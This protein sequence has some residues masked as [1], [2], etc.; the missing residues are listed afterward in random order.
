[1]DAYGCVGLNLCGTMAKEVSV[2]AAWRRRVGRGAEARGHVT[3]FGGE[4]RLLTQAPLLLQQTAQHRT[5]Q[6][7]P[8]ICYLQTRQLH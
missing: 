6:S 5:S 1:M 7:G 4:L 2:V 8:H 3:I